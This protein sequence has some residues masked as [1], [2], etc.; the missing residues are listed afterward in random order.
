MLS[1]L[2]MLIVLH[3]IYFSSICILSF[4]QIIVVILYPLHISQ[5]LPTLQSQL[6]ALLFF[7]QETKVIK[8][9]YPHV[10]TTKYALLAYN[11]LFLEMYCLCSYQ[12]SCLPMCIGIIPLVM[13]RFWSSYHSFS[14]FS[15]SSVF[16]LRWPLP[17]KH[18]CTIFLDQTYL[19]NNCLTSL[20]L[21]QYA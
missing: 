11:L 18:T 19:S 15:A 10:P 4:F 6:K 17:G 1:Y 9:E 13:Q 16:P 2:Y 12:G 14:F 21:Q 5:L 20:S 8:I 7:S 3:S